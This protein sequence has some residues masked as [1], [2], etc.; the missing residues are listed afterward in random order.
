MCKAPKAP[1]PKPPDK[2]EFLHNPYLDAYIGG[3]G[4]VDQL[5]TGRS[6]LRID[7]ARSAGLG[8]RAPPP[9]AAPQLPADPQSARRS[10]N[11][12]I[13]TTG[14]LTFSDPRFATQR[15]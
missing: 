2:P 3:A 7:L 9:A 11:S 5:R 12:P 8:L 13:A 15:R 4:L 14:T 6:S 10:A 1:A